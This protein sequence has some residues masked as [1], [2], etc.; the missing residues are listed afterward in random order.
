MLNELTAKIRIK[1]PYCPWISPQILTGHGTSIKVGAFWNDA[2]AI[3]NNWCKSGNS[4][5]IRV[6]PASKCF[7]INSRSTN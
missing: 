6:E 7:L 2:F 3:V 5:S 4:Y 1:S